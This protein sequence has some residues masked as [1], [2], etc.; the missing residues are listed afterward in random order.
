MLSQLMLHVRSHD[1]PVLWTRTLDAKTLEGM[2]LVAVT[3]DQK[4]DAV[5]RVPRF[6][7]SVFRGAVVTTRR[8]A[9]DVIQCWLDESRYRIRG[10][11]QASVLWRN[12]LEPAL[13]R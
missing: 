2:G 5:L 6:P 4:F 7:E 9:T 11:E 8:P 12:V 3:S 1:V 13:K 10:Q